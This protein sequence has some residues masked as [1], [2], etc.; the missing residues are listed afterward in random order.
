MLDVD[1]VSFGV[2]VT[3]VNV[4]AIVYFIFTF[5][6][7]SGRTANQANI[8]G[9]AIVGHRDSIHSTIIAENI[10]FPY[11]DTFGVGVCIATGTVAVGPVVVAIGCS[12]NRTAGDSDFI[13]VYRCSVEHRHRICFCDIDA[14]G[15]TVT[16]IIITPAVAKAR[17]CRA[18]GV[19]T[20]IVYRCRISSHYKNTE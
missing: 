18:D 4:S 9:I 2:G 10:T 16:G 8:C 11:F 5:A 6:I 12:F 20:G 17:A 13:I 15:I 3:I 7:G 19:S 14:I 1:A